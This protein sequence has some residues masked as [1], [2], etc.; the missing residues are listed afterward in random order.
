MHFSEESDKQNDTCSPDMNIK[1]AL[2]AR[3]NLKN[4]L[5]NNITKNGAYTISN[6]NIENGILDTKIIEGLQTTEI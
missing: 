5:N 2:Q 1:A 4:N 6:G 3:N